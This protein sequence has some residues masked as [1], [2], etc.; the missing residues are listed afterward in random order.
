MTC[1]SIKYSKL[2]FKLTLIYFNLRE[3]QFFYSRK[4]TL[5]Q[6]QIKYVHTEYFHKT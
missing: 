1:N 6:F 3:F 2:V 4:F 5:V